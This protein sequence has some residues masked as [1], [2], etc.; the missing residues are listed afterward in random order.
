MSV[1]EGWCAQVQTQ[2]FDEPYYVVTATAYFDGTYYVV[3]VYGVRIR[4]NGCER[5]RVE[6]GVGSHLRCGE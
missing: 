1:G 2:Y 5:A 3:T 6:A 4:G